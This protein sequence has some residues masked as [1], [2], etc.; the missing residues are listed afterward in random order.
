MG[1]FSP[2]F[3][4]HATNTTLASLTAASGLLFGDYNGLSN[5]NNDDIV[6]V[7]ISVSAADLRVFDT[8]NLAEAASDFGFKVHADA[9]L[10]DVPPMR[11]ADA[12]LLGYV[13]I[14]GG[15]TN[16]ASALWVIWRQI[17]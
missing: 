5:L 14:G 7:Q 11:A 16:D 9:S 13:N 6:Y 4:M 2:Y 10:V 12:S 15:A 3:E 8:N 17:R 1:G